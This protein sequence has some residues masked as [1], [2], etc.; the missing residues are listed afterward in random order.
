ML[1]RKE[2]TD[3]RMVRAETKLTEQLAERELEQRF[4]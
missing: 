3:R 4:L 1:I 2:E